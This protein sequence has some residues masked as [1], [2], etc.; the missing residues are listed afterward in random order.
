MY[1]AS[2]DLWMGLLLPE[3]SMTHGISRGRESS[4]RTAQ[5]SKAQESISGQRQRIIPMSKTAD[6]SLALTCLCDDTAT[7]WIPIQ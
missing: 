6:T 3:A 7:S 2:H 4:E 5:M 1:A